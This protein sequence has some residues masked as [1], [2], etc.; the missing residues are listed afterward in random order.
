MVYLEQIVALEINSTQGSQQA[1]VEVERYES[2]HNQQ[3][4]CFTQ[5][6]TVHKGRPNMHELTIQGSFCY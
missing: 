4:E 3:Y 2:R 6:S 5:L 1:V